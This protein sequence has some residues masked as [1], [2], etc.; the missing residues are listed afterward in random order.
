MLEHIER[1][2]YLQAVNLPDGIGRS[3][4]QNRLLK[5]AR[6]GGQM[7]AAELAK[8]EPQR[9][10]ATLVALVV[11]GI[12]SVTDEIVDLHDRILGRIFSAAKQR[13]QQQF[14]EAGKAINDKVRLYSKIGRALLEARQSGTDAFAA[15]ES[16]IPWDAFVASV[17]DAQKL[18]PS[19]DFDYLPRVADSRYSHRRYH[20]RLLHHCHHHCRYRCGYGYG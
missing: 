18:A 12:A 1:L 19:D 15:I 9:R 14:Q 17:T 20:H 8:F 7:R 5:L 6:E 13:H 3:L 10:Y 11:E 2:K 16:V 4:H